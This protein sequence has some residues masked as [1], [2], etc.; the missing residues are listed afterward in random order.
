MRGL[1]WALQICGCSIACLAHTYRCRRCSRLFVRANHDS[2]C[3]NASCYSCLHPRVGAPASTWL[4][5][6]FTHA[7]SCRHETFVRVHGD[8]LLQPW[9]GLAHMLHVMLGRVRPLA[10][11]LEARIKMVRAM[12]R[13]I[14]A[15]VAFVSDPLHPSSRVASAPAHRICGRER[16]VVRPP[17]KL[18]WSERS[19]VG[20]KSGG[21]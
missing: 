8:V 12:H 11:P 20:E 18:L 4:V 1:E 9:C 10:P 14:D 17:T 16:G 5:K 3:A 15:S 6:S 2:Q 21:R 19:V 13:G 7:G